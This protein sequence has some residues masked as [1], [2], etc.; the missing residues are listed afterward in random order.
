MTG[1]FHHVSFDNPYLDRF[2]EAHA[3]DHDPQSTTMAIGIVTDAVAAGHPGDGAAA[4]KV[5]TGA[6][7]ATAF[8]AT[9]NAFHDEAITHDH[10][11]EQHSADAV[12]GG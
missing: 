8:Q 10:A 3:I 9:M 4:A 7:A 11:A 6:S 2:E 12:R 1:R 5:L